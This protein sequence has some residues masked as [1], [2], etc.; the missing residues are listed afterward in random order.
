MKPEKIRLF[1]DTYGNEYLMALCLTAP[2]EIISWIKE[3]LLQANVPP[4]E[5]VTEFKEFTQGHPRSLLNNFPWDR[6]LSGDY[7]L[8]LLGAGGTINS[9][10]N[11]IGYVKDF[12]SA[13][14]LD[15]PIRI[16][17]QE[18]ITINDTEY[19]VPNLRQLH[20]YHPMVEVGDER[21][22]YIGVLKDD[23][24]HLLEIDVSFDTYPILST[25]FENTFGSTLGKGVIQKFK[26]I[27]TENKKNVLYFIS[28]DENDPLNI[29]GL[30]YK[31]AIVS[32][33]MSR[34]MAR[35]PEIFTN[36]EIENAANAL[37]KSEEVEIQIVEGSKIA[38]FYNDACYIE[39]PGSGSTL[40]K[41]CM[42]SPLKLR[43]VDL[44]CFNPE[45]VK[46]MVALKGGKLIARALVWKTDQGH[47][48]MDRV[49]YT[50]ETSKLFMIKQAIVNGW[51]YKT[52]QSAHSARKF[53]LNGESVP[54]M[55]M[56]VTPSTLVGIN[57][58]PYMDTFKFISLEDKKLLN[59]KIGLCTAVLECQYGRFP[60]NKSVESFTTSHPPFKTLDG[61]IVEIGTHWPVINYDGS[62]CSPVRVDR[63]VIVHGHPGYADSHE[64]YPFTVNGYPSKTQS[65][66]FNFTHRREVNESSSLEFLRLNQ[67]KT[68]SCLNNRKQVFVSTKVEEYYELE[69]SPVGVLGLIKEVGQFGIMCT[70]DYAQ[71]VAYL[72]RFPYSSNITIYSGENKCFY[73]Y[74]DFSAFPEYIEGINFI[75][76]NSLISF[77]ESVEDLW[78]Q[79]ICDDGAFDNFVRESSKRLG[80]SILPE[81]SQDKDFWEVAEEAIMHR[82]PSDDAGQVPVVSVS[83]INGEFV[84]NEI[85]NSHI[86][87]NTFTDRVGRSTTATNT[88][89]ASAQGSSISSLD[90]LFNL[91][92]ETE[93][94]GN[95]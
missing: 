76:F 70:M 80:V 77:I 34:F 49:Y 33:K 59:T 22:K 58:Y 73:I 13:L 3:R 31:G 87:F 5:F 57:H 19:S 74:G 92:A 26:S 62:L 84:F 12:K 56:S 82:V 63:R 37:K 79:Y 69:L 78:V 11:L 10:T 44:Y 50:D 7:Y 45:Q 39:S 91:E 48:F 42:R 72:R 21:F 75:S 94:N 36:E 20:Y 95:E 81:N 6:T 4:N 52:E 9:K 61:E 54:N 38:E 18:V 30:N 32:I 55:T 17:P 43:M 88:S 41:S 47:T 23:K 35:F 8:N 46:L 2:N 27:P 29:T 53:S 86:S 15:R 60:F 24:V 65:E 85:G 68:H 14:K 40:H 90:R 71:V 25:S 28:K 67:I 51:Y 93:E 83:V 64:N 89:R 1:S 16:N 66:A